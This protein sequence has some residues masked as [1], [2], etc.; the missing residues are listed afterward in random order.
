MSCVCPGF[1]AVNCFFSLGIFRISPISAIKLLHVGKT[2]SSIWSI[3][4]SESQV[5]FSSEQRSRVH[6]AENSNMKMWMTEGPKV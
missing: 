1:S 3:E 4:K 2:S 6:E 5:M